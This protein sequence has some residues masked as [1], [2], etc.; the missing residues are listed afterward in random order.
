MRG[1]DICC[2]RPGALLISD[3]CK[4][5][6][7]VG[8]CLLYTNSA[9][10]LNYLVGDQVYTLNHFDVAHYILGYIQRDSRVYVANKDVGKWQCLASLHHT[11]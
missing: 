5:A 9:H 11:C 3:S 8:D 4:T 10:R 6:T 1:K 7:W 2:S